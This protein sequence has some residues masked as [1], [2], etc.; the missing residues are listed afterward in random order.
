MLAASSRLPLILE[1]LLHQHWRAVFAYGCWLCCIVAWFLGAELEAVAAAGGL[2]MI[3]AE[4][5]DAAEPITVSAHWPVMAYISGILI[6]IPG[7]NSTGVPGAFW[8]LVMDAGFVS[9]GNAWGIF[10]LVL[11]T[12]FFTNI[13]TNVPA[14]L[15]LGQRVAQLSIIELGSGD[16]SKLDSPA[17]MRGWLL[18]AFIAAI[19]GSLTVQGSITQVIAYE[20]GK[21]AEGGSVSFVEHLR[22]GV[23]VTML[24]LAIGLPLLLFL[25]DEML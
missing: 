11:V 9:V 22:V 10:G 14:V 1:T 2:A 24:T 15:L 20:I 18:V 19:S 21:S 8:D 16:L 5:K 7:F 6:T 17:A 23:P 12:M 4:W 25:L 13:V 3:L